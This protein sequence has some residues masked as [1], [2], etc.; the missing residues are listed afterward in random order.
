MFLRNNFLSSILFIY[1]TFISFLSADFFTAPISPFAYEIHT[2]C[3]TIYFFIFLYLFSFYVCVSL[4]LLP[5]FPFYSLSCTWL[6][7]YKWASQNKFANCRLDWTET[8]FLHSFVSHFPFLATTSC[9]FD[10][11]KSW[12]FFRINSRSWETRLLLPWRTPAYH[13]A[14]VRGLMDIRAHFYGRETWGALRATYFVPTRHMAYTESSSA[15][16]PCI[17]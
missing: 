5:P 12:L 14:L 16:Y 17:H 11:K 13:N 4:S 9:N 7:T 2:Y 6:P 8:D 15:D 3:S 10:G 1:F